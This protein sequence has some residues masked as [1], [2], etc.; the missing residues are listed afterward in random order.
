MRDKFAK[1][2]L[3]LSLIGIGMSLGIMIS[4]K[5]HGGH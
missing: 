2:L 1:G 3:A 4:N 5:T